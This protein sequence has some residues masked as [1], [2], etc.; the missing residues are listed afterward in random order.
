MAIPRRETFYWKNFLR[1]C[2]NFR[3][4]FLHL[5]PRFSM[6]AQVF[7]FPA[8]GDNESSAAIAARDPKIVRKTC[9]ISQLH[10]VFHMVYLRTYTVSCTIHIYFIELQLVYGWCCDNVLYLHERIE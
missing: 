8:A 3:A 6:A 2:E 1:D 7:Q 9:A 10:D 5:S 4:W